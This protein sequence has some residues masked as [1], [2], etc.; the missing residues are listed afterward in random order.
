MCP[1]TAFIGVLKQK[2]K[3]PDAEVEKVEIGKEKEKLPEP[4][5]AK[6]LDL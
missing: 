5:A 1:E 2:E 6:K 4:I 3:L